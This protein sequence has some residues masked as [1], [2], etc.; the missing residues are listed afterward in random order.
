MNSLLFIAI[1]LIGLLLIIVAYLVGRIQGGRTI[2]PEG[3]PP[4]LLSIYKEI[5]S[6]PSKVLST[7]QGSINP[8]K[9]KVAELL[10]YAELKYDYDIIIPLGQPVDFIGVKSGEKIDFIEVKSGEARL[11]ENEKA[12]SDLVKA[13]KINFRLVL[14]KDQEIDK[15]IK[16]EIEE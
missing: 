2:A 12:I 7:I 8:Q 10:T 3:L 5:Q 4:N 16:S 1:G 6:L 15:V 11:T 13:G 14:I 9:W